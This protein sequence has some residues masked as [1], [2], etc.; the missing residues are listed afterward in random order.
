MFNNDHDQSI[1]YLTPSTNKYYVEGARY[2]CKFGVCYVVGSMRCS[3]YVDANTYIVAAKEQ[4]PIPAQGKEV[5]CCTNTFGV[6][7]P[8]A[9]MVN[10]SG[11]LCGSEGGT[12]Y[13]CFFAFSYIYRL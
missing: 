5:C 13:R 9:I 6:N 10:L 2:Y 11:H 7:K 3:E 4:L 8:Y 1:T 12:F